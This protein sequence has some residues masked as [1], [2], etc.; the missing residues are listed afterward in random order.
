MYN[1]QRA[2][3]SILWTIILATLHTSLGSLKAKLQREWKAIPQEQIATKTARVNPALRGG[4]GL[5]ADNRQAL[6]WMVLTKVTSSDAGVYTCVATGVKPATVTVHV[7]REEA[8]AAMQ[9][10]KTEQSNT[11]DLIHFPNPPGDPWSP[12]VSSKSWVLQ[13]GLTWIYFIS[14]L[15]VLTAMVPLL[16]EI[17]QLFNAVPS[18]LGS[19]ALTVRGSETLAVLG[20]KALAVLGDEALA[21]LESETLTVLGSEALAV[22]GN[23]VLAVLGNEVLAVLRSENPLPL[24]P[25]LITLMKCIKFIL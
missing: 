10:G 20:S 15:Y 4:M 24:S 25:S 9:K 18:V 19:E 1:Q 22:L 6:S 8:P 16:H 7:L 3:T 21:V 2:S 5:V 17:K 11:S 13:P 14:F 23:E 12:T